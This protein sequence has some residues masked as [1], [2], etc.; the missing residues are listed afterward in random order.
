MKKWDDGQ[1]L[2]NFIKNNEREM[3]NFDNEKLMSDQGTVTIC[4]MIRRTVDTLVFHGI[5][6]SNPEA[7]ADAVNRLKYTYVCAKKMQNR[8][9]ALRGHS[10]DLFERID[11]DY[12]IAKR[13][14]RVKKLNG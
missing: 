12:D 4:E 11:A 1:S 5:D 9:V 2:E 6:E 13:I 10:N 3:V 8:I 14:Q 7:F